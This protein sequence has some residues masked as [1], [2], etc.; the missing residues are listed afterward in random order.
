MPL[1]CL[2]PLTDLRWD[3]L[4]KTHPQSSIFHRPEWLKTLADTYN[5][6]PFVL[7]SSSPGTT[8]SDGIAFCKV[9][10][11]ITGNRLVSLPFSDHCEPLL[12][13]ASN[14]NNF[15]EWLLSE[16]K[17]RRLRYIELRP[18]DSSMSTSTFGSG[19]AFWIHNLDLSKPIEDL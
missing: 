6:Q 17:K 5:Y 3:E 8:L 14:E 1:Y 12:S 10:S 19:Q 13:E 16:K 18:I 4:V 2:D 11:W 15:V 9:K 7:T